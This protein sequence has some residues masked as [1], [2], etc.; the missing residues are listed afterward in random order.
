MH[1]LYPKRPS[2]RIISYSEVLD[3]D[4][5]KVER[6]TLCTAVTPIFEEELYCLETF[7]AER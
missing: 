6:E 2:I 7:S 4:L 3:D 5:K 1:P